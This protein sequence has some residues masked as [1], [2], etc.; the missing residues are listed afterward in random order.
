MTFTTNVD[1]DELAPK[2]S[3]ATA[4][5]SLV[6]HC[7]KDSDLRYR[8]FDGKGTELGSFE[9]GDPGYYREEARRPTGTDENRA[10]HDRLAK[11]GGVR[12]RSAGRDV[13]AI[14]KLTNEDLINEHV[15]EFFHERGAFVFNMSCVREEG[16]EFDLWMLQL[17][18]DE[19]QRIDFVVLS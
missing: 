3:R 9:S 12:V 2:M 10:E 11:K 17:A 18:A 1:L 14:A 13:S 7:T 8:W 16:D 5:E 4:S 15:D 6:F 19:L